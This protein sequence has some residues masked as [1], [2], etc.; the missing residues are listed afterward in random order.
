MKEVTKTINAMS[1]EAK[2]AAADLFRKY[3]EVDNA[4]FN[5][6]QDRLDELEQEAVQDLTNGN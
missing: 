1:D 2:E 4:E 6:K 3:G 5:E